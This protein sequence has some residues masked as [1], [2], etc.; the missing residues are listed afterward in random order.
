MKVQ[1]MRKVIIAGLIAA[2]VLPTAAS[3]QSRGE[4]RRDREEVQEQRGDLREAQQRGNRNDIREERHDVREAREELREDR[5]D[6]V[7]SRYVAPY[8]GWHYS[9]VRTGYQLR[10]AFYGLRYHVANPGQYRL[11]PAARNQR[12][13]RYGDDLLLV[14]VRSGRVLQVVRNRY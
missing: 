1:K 10:P 13:V 11:R 14:N 12:W 3:A 6:H 2:I 8:R 5:R 7:R 4:L 9:T